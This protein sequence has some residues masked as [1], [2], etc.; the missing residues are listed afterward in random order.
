MLKRDKYAFPRCIDDHTIEGASTKVV[1]EDTNLGTRMGEQSCVYGRMVRLK[2]FVRDW[3]SFF[4]YKFALT[5]P[6]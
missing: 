3:I 4:S 5:E 2:I 6:G 1:S